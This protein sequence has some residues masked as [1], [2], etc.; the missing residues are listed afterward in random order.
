VADQ[1]YDPLT[2]DHIAS[3]DETGAHPE[4]SSSS[5]CRSRRSVGAPLVGGLGSQ[6]DHK[7]QRRGGEGMSS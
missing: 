3:I 7:Q 5:R 1:V 2:E 6:Q 4:S